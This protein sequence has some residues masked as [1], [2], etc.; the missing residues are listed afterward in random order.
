MPQLVK[1]K[2]GES[3]TI[4][5]EVP[6]EEGIRR[7]GKVKKLLDAADQAFDRLVQNEIVENCKVLVGAFEQLKE[8]SLPP[9]KA[10]A[11]FG[12]QFNTEGNIYVVKASGQASIKISVEWELS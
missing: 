2:L 4:L 11:E 1:M 6:E 10:S 9:R 3:G 12:L 5:V 7:V 8:Q